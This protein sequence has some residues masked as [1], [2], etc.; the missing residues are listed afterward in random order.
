MASP[1]V[2]PA[3]VCT[4]PGFSARR[5]C[6]CA[7]SHRSHARRSSPG[8]KRSQIAPRSVMRAARLIARVSMRAAWC[9]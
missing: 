9:S 7:R 1:R 2:A 5:A 6:P 8:G 4:V 3:L